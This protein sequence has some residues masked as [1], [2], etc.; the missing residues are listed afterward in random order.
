MVRSEM[1]I[2]MIA[3]RAN[4]MIDKIIGKSGMIVVEQ[5]APKKVILRNNGN[6]SVYY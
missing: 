6:G 4:V 5:K 2:R 1:A 3:N